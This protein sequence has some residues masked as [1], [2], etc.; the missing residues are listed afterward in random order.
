M[1]VNGARRC[2]RLRRRKHLRGWDFV[3]RLWFGTRL[4][5]HLLKNKER[6]GKR[7]E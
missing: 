1:T 4:R 2:W 6:I 3:G 7:S 5:L